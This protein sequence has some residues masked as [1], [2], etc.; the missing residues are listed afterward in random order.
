MFN[1]ILPL[2]TAT[3]WG[4]TTAIGFI[5]NERYYWMIDEDGSISMMPA[6]V[7]EELSHVSENKTSLS[8]DDEKKAETNSRK[9][10]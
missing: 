4:K 6:M 3:A 7:V 1:I 8:K 2:G 9:T 10:K 5:E